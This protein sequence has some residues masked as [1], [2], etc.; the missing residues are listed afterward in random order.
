MP[1]NRESR[2]AAAQQ[3]TELAFLQAVARRVPEDTNIMRALGDLYT[4]TGAV[5]EGLEMDQRLSRLCADDPMVWYNLA[6]SLSLCGRSDDALD[7]LDRAV[8]LGY[9]DYEWMKQDADLA[10]L[11]GDPRF[12]SLLEWIYCTFEQTP[13]QF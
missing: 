6:C 5:Q 3:R 10:G 7:A 2:E 13:G 8:E 4:Q 11:R 9:D 1:E 12:E